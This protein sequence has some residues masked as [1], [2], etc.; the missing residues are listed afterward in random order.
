MSSGIGQLERVRRLRTSVV[1]LIISLA[2][3]YYASEITIK[4]EAY[5]WIQ[6]IAVASGILFFV[7][8]GMSINDW[9]SE[10]SIRSKIED[11]VKA[12]TEELRKSPEPEEGEAAEAVGED[13]TPQEFNIT[14]LIE[15]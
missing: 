2:G 14:D 12:E 3:L 5:W 7:G 11:K 13:E 15:K 6:L 1:F 9:K 4:Y 10:R 8:I